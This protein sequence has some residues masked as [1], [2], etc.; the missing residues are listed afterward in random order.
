MFFTKDL[1][2]GQ[3]FVQEYFNVGELIQK[4]NSMFS[5]GWM[6]VS[7]IA[8]YVI[9]ARKN[10]KVMFVISQFTASHYYYIQ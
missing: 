5:Q 3:G 9:F 8:G 10:S 7:F 2:K 6:N 4:C 1:S